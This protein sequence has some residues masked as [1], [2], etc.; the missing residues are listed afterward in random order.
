MSEFRLGFLGQ[1]SLVLNLYSDGYKAEAHVHISSFSVLKITLIVTD[2][3]Y[4]YECDYIESLL[5]KIKL[6]LFHTIG[7]KKALYENFDFDLSV[8]F[9]GTFAN[10]PDF[11]GLK[12]A[13]AIK[14]ISYSINRKLSDLRYDEEFEQSKENEYEEPE[15][16]WDIFMCMIFG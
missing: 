6:E 13:D 12:F 11:V 16:L 3:I 9:N 5:E 2:Y 7:I 15:A 10:S 1:Q 14:G 4:N 8:Y